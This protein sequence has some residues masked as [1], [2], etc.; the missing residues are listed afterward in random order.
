MI[1]SGNEVNAMT[2]V[3]A[4]KLGF[5][6]RKTRVEAQKID[7]STID[8][9]GMASARFSLQNSLG[10]VRFVEET[11]LLADTSR[12]VILGMLFLSLNNADVKFAEKPEKLTWRS[13]GTAVLP[14][15]SRVELI[16]KKRIC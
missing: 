4:A 15:T 9:Y 3:Y 8:T 13:Y 14:T 16:D 2:P 7:G 11:L 12:E 5:T 10:R 6:T 1:D